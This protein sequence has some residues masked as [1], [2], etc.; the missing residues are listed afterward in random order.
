MLLALNE[1]C[2]KDLAVPNGLWIVSLSICRT[3]GLDI[4]LF[5]SFNHI[6][7]LSQLFFVN[8]QKKKKVNVL[9]VNIIS[10]PN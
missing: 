10:G 8:Y 6:L 5:F 4:Y 2:C 1:P 7:F 3:S 9:S